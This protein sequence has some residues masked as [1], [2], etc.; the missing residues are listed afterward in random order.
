V[1]YESCNRLVLRKPDPL[2]NNTDGIERNLAF[3]DV[4]TRSPHFYM[5]VPRHLTET[6]AAV[7][8]AGAFVC[9][10]VSPIEFAH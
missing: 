9:V 10:T 6:H 3:I 4:T 5:Y 8:P 2:L 7:D 1:H